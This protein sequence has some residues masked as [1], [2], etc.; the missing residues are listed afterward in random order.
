[1]ADNPRI[2]QFRQMTEADPQNELGHFSLGK[3][4]LEEG[5]AG[6]A[7]EPLHRTVQ[8]NPRMSKAHQLLA[9]ALEKSGQRTK[10]IESL[11]H[12]F[13]VADEQG[14]RMVCEAMASMLRDWGADVPKST[15][16][17]QKEESGTSVATESE[18]G[19]KCARCGQPRGQLPKPPF[20]GALGEAVY[21]QTCSACW[22]EWIPM[23]TKVIN[24]LGLVLST[25]QGGA[26]YDQY[27][28]EFL[29]LDG[30]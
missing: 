17:A 22:R 24:E 26:T 7:V 30:V 12:G 21:R 16:T 14:D 2:A 15:A 29:Q 11:T 19:F 8:L 23:G 5:D 18:A 4:L 25:K 28:A 20:K 10:A 13:K 1:M 6:A 3:A 27:M 9:E